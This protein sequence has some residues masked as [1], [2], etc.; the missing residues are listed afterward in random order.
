MDE[1]T[2]VAK[3]HAWLDTWDRY[4]TKGFQELLGP[5]FVLFENARFLSREVLTK[6]LDSLAE[7]HAPA[8][9]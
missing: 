5:T 7:R 6:R 3:S 2:L 9:S 8:A 1:A 4:D